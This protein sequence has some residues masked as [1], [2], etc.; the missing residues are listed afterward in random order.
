MLLLYRGIYGRKVGDS[1]FTFHYA[2]TLSRNPR[3]IQHWYSHLHST[4]LLL[5]RQCSMK[6]AALTMIYIPLCFYFILPTE[7]GPRA[8]HLIYI[9]LCFYFIGRREWLHS[10]TAQF[11]FHYASTLSLAIRKARLCRYRFTFHYASTL[12]LRIDIRVPD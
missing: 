9:P 7:S 11:T 12:S 2:S 3:A 5:Y 4:M 6:M 1:I 8:R 10:G